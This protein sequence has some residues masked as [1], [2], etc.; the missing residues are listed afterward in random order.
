MHEEHYGR[1]HQRDEDP[2]QQV[3]GLGFHRG[4]LY[5]GTERMSS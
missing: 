3:V 4:G 1:E 5:T 2:V